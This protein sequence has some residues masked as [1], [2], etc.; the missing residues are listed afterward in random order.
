MKL[1]NIIDKGVDH[2]QTPHSA[3]S[4][5]GLHCLLMSLLRDAGHKW[6][7]LWKYSQIREI[8]GSVCVRGG[9]WGRG[10]MAGFQNHNQQLQLLQLVRRR[11]VQSWSKRIPAL[12]SPLLFFFIISVALIALINRHSGAQ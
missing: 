8:L 10:D 7:K 9:G 3:A 11:Q 5:L 2:E 4:D 12:S 1:S 6:V